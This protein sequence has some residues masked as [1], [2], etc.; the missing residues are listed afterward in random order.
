M[1]AC[2]CC[3][4]FVTEAIARK[5]LVL[6]ALLHTNSR[7]ILDGAPL[8]PGFVHRRHHHEG[9]YIC[10]RWN[11]VVTSIHDAMTHPIRVRKY[12]LGA[13]LVFIVFIF[14]MLSFATQSK[15]A[16]PPACFLM[17]QRMNVRNRPGVIK[18][19]SF[20]SMMAMCVKCMRT[21]LFSFSDRW[22]VEALFFCCFFCF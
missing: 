10:I 16:K 5:W 21:F 8:L 22:D 19:K 1:P 6:D 17:W 11:A 13:S 2:V 20:A 12:V 9:I 15:P 7:K 4:W 3:N 18:P 14:P